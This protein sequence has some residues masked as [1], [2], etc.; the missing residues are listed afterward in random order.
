MKWLD[1]VGRLYEKLR[2]AILILILLLLVAGSVTVFLWATGPHGIGVRSDS[3]A[4]LWSSENLVK[5]IGLGRLNGLGEFRPMTHWPPLYPFLLA[6]PQW[7]G[8]NSLSAARLSGSCKH[9]VDGP[10]VR[11]EH[12]PA[13]SRLT[14]VHR[15]GDTGAG[16]VLCNVGYQPVRHDRTTLHDTRAAG[17]PFFGQLPQLK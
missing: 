8:L 4:Y 16:D 14:L 9:R 17:I 15:F 12:F 6:L 1:A 13:H 3:V 7:F 10:V 11:G 2:P 5:G